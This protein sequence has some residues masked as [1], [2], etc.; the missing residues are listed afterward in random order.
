MTTYIKALFFIVII[1]ILKI[2]LL[3]SIENKVECLSKRKI[4]EILTDYFYFNHFISFK[5]YPVFD[6]LSFFI[7]SM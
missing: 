3:N 7:F 5:A 6:S 2:I 4:I 1:I